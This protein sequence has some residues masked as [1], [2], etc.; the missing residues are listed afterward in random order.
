[1]PRKTKFFKSE[2]TTTPVRNSKGEIETILRRY[3]ASGFSVAEDYHRGIVVISFVV[4]DHHG[5]DAAQVPVKL[6][7]NIGKI[8]HIIYGVEPRMGDRGS[9]WERAE[10]VAWRNLVLWIDAA[11]SAAAAGLQ[12]ITEAFF[13]HA[14]VDQTGGRRMIEVVAEAADR[15]SP[16]VGL[17]LGS[18]E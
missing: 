1:M 6:P 16:G 2:N 5:K 7:I 17:M 14:V 4:P 18:G 9:D 13:A 8:Y 3:G 11:L 15:M 12:T 10:R